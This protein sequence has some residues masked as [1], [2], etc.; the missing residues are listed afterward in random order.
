MSK[1]YKHLQNVTEYKQASINL[2]E[3]CRPE[4]RDLEQ[5][6][7]KICDSWWIINDDIVKIPESHDHGCQYEK[8]Q[9]A[10]QKMMGDTK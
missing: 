5:R 8:F 7:C 9:K 10:R 6:V 2:A 4:E 1:L 3:A